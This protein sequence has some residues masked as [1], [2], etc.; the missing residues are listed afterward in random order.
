MKRVVVVGASGLLGSTLVPVLRSHG[1]DVLALSRHTEP[2][3][4]D[5]TDAGSAGRALDALRPDA[6]VNLAALT[7]VDECEREPARAYLLNAHVV[8]NLAAWVV[9]RGDG[10]HL[11]QISTDQLYDGGGPHT[12][13]HVRP[14]NYY[15]YSKYV[16]ELHAV[17]AVA[18]ILRTNLF[19]R[20]RCA[21]RQSL[22]DW[23]VGVL[24]AGAPAQVF[25]DVLFSALSLE[26]LAGMIALTLEKRR[27]GT[28]NLGSREGLSK[29][30]FAFHL[31][32]AL[33][34]SSDRLVVANSTDTGRA[35]R[36]PKDMRMD[37]SR[38]ESEYAVRLPTLESE[39]QSLR[40]SY[41][42]Q[43]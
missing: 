14:I 37:C 17:L 30:D 5:L 13:D 25:Q 19:G 31:A 27:P 28:F 6:I 9:A 43:A 15:A 22:S 8:R 32:R 3:G 4:A 23:L 29:A 24:R 38:F 42:T 7:N 11:V 18:T 40:G 41:A 12:E 33:G 34:L 10:C 26:T 16:G 35:A 21:G 1:Y 20:S 2:L 39:I 36:R